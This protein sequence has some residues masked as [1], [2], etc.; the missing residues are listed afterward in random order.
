MRQTTRKKTS[1]DRR[2]AEWYCEYT[3]SGE[4][5]EKA[6]AAK[7][8]ERKKRTHHAET[9]SRASSQDHSVVA[10]VVLQKQ[11]GIRASR[12]TKLS[13]LR[14][15]IPTAQYPPRTE[16]QSLRDGPDTSPAWRQP[17][18]NSPESEFRRSSS[19]GRILHSL[20]PPKHSK[21]KA[22]YSSRERSPRPDFQLYYA[23]NDE[24]NPSNHTRTLER[25]RKRKELHVSGK[26]LGRSD[27]LDAARSRPRP[28]TRSRSR[29]L[30]RSRSRSRSRSYSPEDFND[31]LVSQ[32]MSN[33]LMDV[34]VDIITELELFMSAIGLGPVCVPNEPPEPPP[35]TRYKVRK[36]CKSPTLM[37]Q[38]PP[39]LET[40]FTSPKEVN[41]DNEPVPN[42][43]EPL[44][45][46]IRRNKQ[47]FAYGVGRMASL[48]N[49]MGA[50][51]GERSRMPKEKARVKRK[52]A[53]HIK[54]VKRASRAPRKGRSKG[55]EIR[56]PI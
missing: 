25:S 41:T 14:P 30:S 20:S 29:S 37:Y 31:T 46:E 22:H 2:N 5:S 45:Q 12:A 32:T 21:N 55:F 3:P 4:Q 6:A 56:S 44:E 39:A 11:K 40:A 1:Y 43:E 23:S 50:Y 18:S 36:V 19:P 38:A 16:E 27:L 42:E 48:D 7:S 49:I 10:S 26:M 9:A 54:T 34:A 15:S 51:R 13:V 52:M 17:K 24:H 47:T 35:P 33:A 28:S 53:Q 8:S